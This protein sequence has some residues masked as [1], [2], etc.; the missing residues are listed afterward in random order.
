MRSKL[1]GRRK[2]RGRLVEQLSL[3]KILSRMPSLVLYK[4]RDDLSSEG[5]L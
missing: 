4:T 1:R 2:R 3:Q 5:K